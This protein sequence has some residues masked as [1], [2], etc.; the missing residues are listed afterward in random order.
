MLQMSSSQTSS[1]MTEK[2]SQM[3]DLSLFFAFYVNNCGR[4][5]CKFNNDGGLLSSALL[6]KDAFKIAARC[7]LQ[8]FLWVQ[9]LYIVVTIFQKF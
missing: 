1:I 9:K 8:N 5:K 4:D 3:A 6:F 7:Q 2:K